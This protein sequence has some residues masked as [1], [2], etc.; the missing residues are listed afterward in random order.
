MSKMCSIN[1]ATAFVITLAREEAHPVLFFC[2]ERRWGDRTSE[3]A[4]KIA[5]TNDFRV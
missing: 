4:L 5:P 1:W 2:Y 3:P